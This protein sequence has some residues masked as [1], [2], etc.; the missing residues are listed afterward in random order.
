MLNIHT[1]LKMDKETINAPNLTDKFDAEDLVAIGEAVWAT[2][3]SDRRSR[4]GWMRR[5][6]PAMDLALQVQKDKSF[7][8]PNCSN[9]AF[10]LITIAALQFHSRA[11]PTL[12]NGPDIVNFRVVGPDPDGSKTQQARRIGYYMSYQLL[13]Q[14]E[15]WEPQQDRALLNVPIVGV[16]WKKTYYDAVRGHN[17]SDL[18]LARDLVL[19]YWAKSVEDCPAKTHILS[20]S[21]NTIYSRIMEGTFKDVRESEWFNSDAP[22]PPQTA[23]TAERDNRAG[24]TQPTSS[25]H[26]PYICLEQH[27]YFDFDSDGYAEPYIVTIE[28]NTHE[29]LRI[30]TRFDREQDIERNQDGDII[31]I[32]P[33]EYFTKIPF[34]PN[35]DGSIMDIGFGTLLGPLNESVN[36]AINQ[37]FDSGTMSNTAGGFLGRGAKIRGGVYSFKPF[38]WNRVDS[39]GDDLKKSV[40]PLPVREPSNVL[41]N[42]LSLLITYTEKISGAVDISTGGNPGQN[43]PA[44]TSQ[45]MIE[46]GQKV[47]AAIFKR[48]WRSMK[49][50]FKK[51]YQLNGIHLPSNSIFFAGENNYISRSDFLGDPT[52]IVPVADPNVM[53]DTARLAQATALMKVGSMNPLYSQDEI[54]KT[55]LKAIKINNIDQIY[56]GM[57]RAQPLAPPERV[58]VEM[59]KAQV[60]LQNLEWKKLQF[61]TSL[62]EQR[63]L[64]EANIVK[65]YAQAALFEQQAGGQQAAS[66]ISAF[67]SMISAMKAWNEKLTS[68]INEGNQNEAGQQQPQQQQPGA[69][70][71]PGMASI[72]GDPEASGMVQPPAGNL[73]GPLVPR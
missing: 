24:Q 12:L 38:S 59:L 15:T 27:T 28:E 34:I 3:E 47:Y 69:G 62:Y 65:A 10:P 46:Q 22:N 61:M 73:E 8:W 53:S 71:V 68:Q 57:Q 50:E 44:S 25:E 54:N 21:R 42:L 29:I 18:V 39:S 43:T 41:Y 16:A 2:Y 23:D 14:D 52:A 20:L 13:E 1:K 45:T 17:V 26:T 19:N 49:L 70:N 6:Q 60:Q 7:P 5:M 32:R 31:R 72:P 67:E 11:Y 9:V 63:R 66:Q 36:T 35:P 30:V 4:E 55:Y 37:L 58:Q 48:I 51:L 56:L 33:T 40:L 64:N